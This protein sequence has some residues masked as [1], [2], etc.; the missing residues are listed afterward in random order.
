MAPNSN[1]RLATAGPVALP[2]AVLVLEGLIGLTLLRS[3]R[4]G[5]LADA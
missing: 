3:D 1:D 2:L 4:C 5:A